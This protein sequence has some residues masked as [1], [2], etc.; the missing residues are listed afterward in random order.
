[1]VMQPT[2]EKCTKL[3]RKTKPNFLLAVAVLFR[4][5]CA[6]S[7]AL[8]KDSSPKEL[9]LGQNGFFVLFVSNFLLF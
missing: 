7:K 6:T 5:V 4:A 9:K 1:M 8:K 3:E 2:R